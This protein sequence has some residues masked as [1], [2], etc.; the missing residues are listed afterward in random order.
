M[1][2]LLCDAAARPRRAAQQAVRRVEA[3]A[4][5]FAECAPVPPLAAAAGTALPPQHPAAPWALDAAAG[6]AIAGTALPQ[7]PL[8]APCVPFMPPAVP[9]TPGIWLQ[10]LAPAPAAFPP[11]PGAAPTA[12]AAVVPAAAQQLPNDLQEFVRV[13]NR[14]SIPASPGPALDHACLLS[15]MERHLAAHHERLNARRQQQR[16]RGSVHGPGPGPASLGWSDAEEQLLRW[17]L[18]LVPKGQG[19][20]AAQ[21]RQQVEGHLHDAGAQHLCGLHCS[22]L[23]LVWQAWH[24]FA[25]LRTPRSEG[26]TKEH[27]TLLRRAGA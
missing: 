3:A 15:G 10:P 16:A 12:A 13:L 18:G 2:R 6:A 1:G 27:A 11:A 22:P 14:M 25:G 4:E 24:H 21:W 23:Y 20:R 26:A 19:A 17:C 7:P 9:D 5:A 8:A